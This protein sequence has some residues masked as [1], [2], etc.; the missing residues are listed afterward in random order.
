MRTTLF[1][2]LLFVSMT[3]LGQ[4][5][6]YPNIKEYGAVVELEGATLPTKPAKVIIDITSNSRGRGGVSS[7]MDRVA[8]LINLYGLA[9]ISSEE[10]DITV[11]IHGGA[12]KAVLSEEAY[13][14]KFGQPNPDTP[15]IDAL[16]TSRS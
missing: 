11:I 2:I 13:Q 3:T 5:Y 6:Q 14:D 9:G 16:K 1:G 10:L 12:T 15:I 8:R 7:S 4:E